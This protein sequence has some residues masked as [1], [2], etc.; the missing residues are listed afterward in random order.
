MPYPEKFKKSLQQHNVDESIISKIFEGY[1]ELK[2]KSPKREKTA[3]FTRAIKQVDEMFDENQRIQIMD[4][5]ACCKGGKRDKAV[6]KI[7][8]ELKAK[9]LEEKVKALW[10]VENMGKPI[11]K[12]DGTITTGI[13]YQGEEGYKCA[14]SCLSNEE[15]SEPISSTYCL[16][17]AGH[18]RYHYQNALGVKLKIKQI[19]SSPL[20]SLG[21]EPCVFILEIVEDG[22]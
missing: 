18:F 8:K 7:A 12:D 21:K 10:Q 16:C 5:C 15:L 20:E 14:C 22:F 17:C 2:D 1:E 19:V 13:Y 11:L 9:S 3:F 4:W 6:K